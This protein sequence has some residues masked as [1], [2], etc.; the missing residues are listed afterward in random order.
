MEKI[1]NILVTGASGKVGR[2]LIPELLKAGFNVRAVQYS[3]PISFEGAE[4][5]RG[6]IGDPEFAPKA[7]EGMDAVIHLANVKENKELFMRS[8]IQ[9]TFYLLD[10]CMKSSNIKQFIQAGSDA[11]AGIYFNPRPYPIDENFPH[12]AYPGYYAFS[13]VLEETMCEQYIRQYNMPVTILR[14]SWIHDEDD[15]LAHATLKEPNFGIP[16]WKE[17]AEPQEQKEFFEKGI[18]A[19]ACM[20]HPD[21]KPCKRQIV[22]IKDVVHSCMIA[23][24]N[25]ASYGEAFSISGPS[26]FSY[27]ALAKYISEKMDI[28][29]V[30]FVNPIYC[31][32]QHCLEKSRSV[33]G[34]NPKYDIYKIVDNA[35]EFRRAGKERSKLKYPG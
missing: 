30:E 14:F 3:T 4:I 29:V 1:K 25:K 13:K 33:L 20:T 35:I 18:D 28:P 19:A 31:D 21:G 5:F 17:L 9:G 10:A 6:D 22:G 27:E 32:F 34:Y 15:I 12:W 24:G 16:E 26:S 2:N 7:I 23:I 8:N 11:R